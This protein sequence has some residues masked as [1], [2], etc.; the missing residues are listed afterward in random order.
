MAV[1]TT[2]NY[3][4]DRTTLITDALSLIGV[5]EAT[6]D[7]TNLAIRTLNALVRMLD[8]KGQWLWAVSNTESSL[9]L[10]ANQ[11][12]YA[13]G[14]T[15]T[16]INTSILK[17]EWAAVYVGTEYRDLHILDK[18]Q[19]FRTR[20]KSDGTGEPVEVYLERKKLLADNRMLFFPTPNAAYTVKYTFRR[21]LYDFDTA[22]D[23]PDFP[24]EFV[25]PLQKLLACELAPHFGTPLNE[26]Q[27]NRAEAEFQFQ[28]ATAASADNASSELPART[29]Y[30]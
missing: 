30:F 15:A 20:R 8:A 23:N 14:I 3:D 24:S 25:L 29:V 10:V 19:S 27:L 12:A 22:T 11:Q 9:T 26:R 4:V 18:G 6:Q 5:T 7:E 16:T 21:P 13:T 17:L 1:G 2:A 28:E